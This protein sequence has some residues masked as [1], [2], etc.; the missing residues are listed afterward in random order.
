MIDESLKQSFD[1]V[2]NGFLSIFKANIQDK[3]YQRVGACA[4]ATVITK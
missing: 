3:K 2:E 4:L 1:D